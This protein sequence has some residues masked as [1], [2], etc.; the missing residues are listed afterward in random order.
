MF[1]QKRATAI[2]GKPRRKQATET[3]PVAMTIAK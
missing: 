2:Q 1:V 3:I